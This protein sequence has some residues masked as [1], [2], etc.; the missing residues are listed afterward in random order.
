MLASTKKAPA[1]SW[2]SAEPR[3]CAGDDVPG[4]PLSMRE[5]VGIT[6]IV[7]WPLVLAWR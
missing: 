4:K 5:G 7:P 6:L 2:L 1:V 3:D